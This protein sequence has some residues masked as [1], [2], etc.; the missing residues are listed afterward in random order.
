M[1]EKDY[2]KIVDL[3]ITVKLS[4]TEKRKVRST[5]IATLMSILFLIAWVPFAFF[6]QETP[7]PN[8][9]NLL[10]ILFFVPTSEN[11]I[12]WITKVYINGEWIPGISGG[13]TKAI[14][15]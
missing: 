2:A 4:E 8:Y 6:L 10:G 13:D 1:L 5:N 11:S 3:G 12:D 7:I 15:N 14:R 9:V